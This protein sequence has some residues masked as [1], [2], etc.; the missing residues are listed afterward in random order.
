MCAAIVKTMDN[1]VN[2]RVAVIWENREDRASLR[3]AQQ[4]LDRSR[5][6]PFAE[7]DSPADDPFRSLLEKSTGW[8]A[9]RCIA[10]SISRVSNLAGSIRVSNLA[11]SLEPGERVWERFADVARRS[12]SLASGSDLKL[13]PRGILGDRCDGINHPHEPPERAEG[14][15]VGATHGGCTDWPRLLEGRHHFCDYGVF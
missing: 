6:A 2:D 15:V 7:H 1:H 4:V 3:L 14:F 13:L 10:G 8:F 12:L 9:S 5:A 11:R